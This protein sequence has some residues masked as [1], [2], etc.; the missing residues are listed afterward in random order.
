M[1]RKGSPPPLENA[2]MFRDLSARQKTAL[3]GISLPCEFRRGEIIFH[4]G[5]PSVG[6]YL[7]HSGAVNVHRLSRDGTERLIRI[8]HAG[9]SFAEASLLSGGVYPATARAMID[10]STHLIPKAPFLSL[11]E[12]DASFGLRMFVALSIRIHDMAGTIENLRIENMRERLLRWLI[13]RRPPAANPVSYTISLTTTKAALAAE[14]GM[15]QETLSRHL[16]SLRKS[17]DLTVNGREIVV[18]NSERLRE[19]LSEM[20]V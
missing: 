13:A 5:S 17:G 20:D 10:C 3:A 7:I 19:L 16:A 11:L 9:E 6:F 2:P 18:L 8:F 14:L 4:Q 1:N 15:R 12:R